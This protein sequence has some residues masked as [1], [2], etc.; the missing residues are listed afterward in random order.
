MGKG[1]R[2]VY[3]Q[4]KA[5]DMPETVTSFVKLR[6]GSLLKL[7]GKRADLSHAASGF[8]YCESC[9]NPEWQQTTEKVLK[10]L[11]NEIEIRYRQKKNTGAQCAE[12]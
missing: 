11:A 3:P 10:P 5:Q 4:S 6:K 1:A 9:V 7:K 12:K 2:R 8:S